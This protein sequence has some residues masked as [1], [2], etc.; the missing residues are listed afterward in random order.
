MHSNRLCPGCGGRVLLLR[1]YQ[2]CLNC[3]WHETA[4][5]S[6]NIIRVAGTQ[7]VWRQWLARKRCRTQ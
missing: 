6:G 3:G 2:V 7:E 4:T 1:R 5:G